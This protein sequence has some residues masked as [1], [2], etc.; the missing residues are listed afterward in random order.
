MKIPK[1]LEKVI[2][3]HERAGGFSLEYL[4]ELENPAPHYPMSK[5]LKEFYYAKGYLA[6][7]QAVWFHRV[8][9]GK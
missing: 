6:A 3:I 8:K 5:S 9:G 2:K 4:K 7:M 1:Y